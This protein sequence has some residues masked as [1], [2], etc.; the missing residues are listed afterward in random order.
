[1]RADEGDQTRADGWANVLT[2]IGTNR[3]KVTAA[4]FASDGQLDFGTLESLYHNDDMAAKICD[5]VPQQMHR[6]GFSLSLGDPAAEGAVEEALAALCMAD[7]F[8]EGD[9]WGRLYGGAKCLIGATDGETDPAKPLNEN[10]LQ[11]IDFLEVYDRYSLFPWKYYLDQNKPKFGQPETY[12]VIQPYAGAVYGGSQVQLGIE[13]HE[14]RLIH[15]GGARTSLRKR[16]ANLGWDDS[17]LQRCLQTLTAFGVQWASITHLLSDASQ[18]VLKIK[19]LLAMIA[20]NNKEQLQARGE[21]LDKT[22]SVARLLMVDA[23]TEDFTRVGTPFGGIPELTDRLTQRLAAA[24]DMP[25]TVLMGEAPAGLSATGD[26]DIRNW[27]DKIAGRQERKLDPQ[28]RALVRLLMLAKKGPTGGRVFKQVKVKFNSLWQ[29]TPPEEATYRKTVAETDAIYIDKTVIT[30]EEVGVS[31]FGARGYSAETSI[32]LP[33]R[34]DLMAADVQAA[35]LAGG[36][37]DPAE[38]PPPADAKETPKDE[39][40][41]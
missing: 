22:R 39:P 30:A 5:E 38:E 32:D 33:L 1:M 4:S 21:L 26:S 17:V 12:R 37:P 24:A 41:A 19:N 2:G 34:E 27:Y 8:E 20:G 28:I 9:T 14:T 7:K 11:S 35:Q 3:D 15:F 18:G 29:M 10:K 23:D 40:K 31:R 25:V 16:R 6:E 13:V 36:K